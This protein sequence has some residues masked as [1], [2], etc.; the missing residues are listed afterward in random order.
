MAVGLRRRGKV[1][2]YPGEIV[3]LFEENNFIWEE[4]GHFDILHF[5]YRPEI[6]IKARYFEAAG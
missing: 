2:S 6:L 3:E 5:E 1:V 4:N